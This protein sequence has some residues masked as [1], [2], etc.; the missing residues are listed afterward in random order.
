MSSTGL[1]VEVQTIL[2]NSNHPVQKLLEELNFALDLR[3]D[4]LRAEIQQS[5]CCDTH[6]RAL[7]V[8][9]E[10][11][12]VIKLL[13]M[14]AESIYDAFES[15]EEDEGTKHSDVNLIGS[16]ALADEQEEVWL[17][18]PRSRRLDG[19]DS[20]NKP[21][22]RIPHDFRLF[23]NNRLRKL[24][25]DLVSFRLGYVDPRLAALLHEVVYER[26]GTVVRVVEFWY[27]YMPDRMGFDVSNQVEYDSM[28]TWYVCT[29]VAGTCALS[30][31]LDYSRS[32]D[33]HVQ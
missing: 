10:L 22:S 18:L 28:M 24:G 27:I 6:V 2:Y 4:V 32:Y 16:T 33:V 21:C 29:A 5:N 25:Q 31:R 12:Q 17:L 9:Q 23:C 20:S 13:D 11:E 15:G 14:L 7:W 26:L 19:R 30:L 1:V 3:A 8:L